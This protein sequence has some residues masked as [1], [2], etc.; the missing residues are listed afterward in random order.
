MKAC[1]TLLVF[2]ALA[3]A[4]PAHAKGSPDLIVISGG[5]LA[6]A[7]EITDPASLRAFD[8]WSGQFADW[9]QDAVAEPACYRRSYEVLF[10]MK[11][12]GRKS[13][14][15]RGELKMIYATRYC[16]ADDAGYVYLPAGDE[17]PHVNM[18]TIIRADRS[19]KWSR[20]LK[21]QPAQ[22]DMILITGGELKQPLQVTDA[23]ALR[24]FDPWSAQ[25]VDW[26]RPIE[27]MRCGWEYEVRFF[28]R[29]VERKT[30]YDPYGFNM[31][32]GV[33][34]CLDENG[35]PGYIHL[36]GRNDKFGPENVVNAWDARHA[37]KWYPAT[38]EW[39]KL[40]RTTVKS[41]PH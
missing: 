36:A 20:S 2:A 39:D 15:D 34:Y 29:G 24:N 21:E 27:G 31:V 8:P 11:W 32:Y 41:H 33:R 6:R 37:G 18:G 38:A 9:K 16:F 26:E 1:L 25:F 13:P 7:V 14:L 35:G 17:A 12:P 3:A 19:G 5:G 10:Y 23:E 22:V 30:P 28:R 4:S 40:I